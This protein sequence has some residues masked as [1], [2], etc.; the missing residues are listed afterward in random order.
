MERDGRPVPVKFFRITPA[1][2]GE[3]AR[4]YGPMKPGPEDVLAG[5][6]G[7]DYETRWER[8]RASKQATARRPSG[9]EDPTERQFNEITSQLGDVEE[10]TA[11][12]AV[13][14][15]RQKMRGYI[16]QCGP[17][18]ATVTAI[19]LRLEMEHMSASDRTVR[20]WLSEDEA[21]GVVEKVSHSVYRIRDAA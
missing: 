2:V 14:A 4:K 9:P 10:A 15:Q 16:R 20:R 3:V 5:A 12:E 18:G 17:K 13:S 8:F 21:R 1:Q 7:E 6:L 11:G 19:V